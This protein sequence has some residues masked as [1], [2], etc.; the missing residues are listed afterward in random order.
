M[1]S[2]R[3]FPYGTALSLW[4]VGSRARGFQS[5][6]KGFQ[7]V[8]GSRARG[9][10]GMGFSTRRRGSRARR[11]QDAGGSRAHRLSSC[12]V[13]AYLLLGTWSLPGPGIEPMLPPLQGGFST[14]EPPGKPQ[15]FSKN[16]NE[17]AL[18]PLSFSHEETEITVMEEEKSA[19]LEHLSNLNTPCRNIRIFENE[20]SPSAS[21]GAGVC[22]R[23][24]H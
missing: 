8:G 5:V 15:Q 3:V 22:H 9:L 24:S 17:S 6:A 14:P 16:S 10:Q 2:C 18:A 21:L 12:A 4:R 1:T 19:M 13:W 20:I 23:V 7:S 11:L